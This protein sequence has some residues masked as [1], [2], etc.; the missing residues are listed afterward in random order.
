MKMVQACPGSGAAVGSA[1]GL[2]RN[3]RKALISGETTRSSQDRNRISGPGGHGGGWETRFCQEVL[4]C[5]D[6]GPA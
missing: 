3:H 6:R 5:A 1:D 4:V 2:S